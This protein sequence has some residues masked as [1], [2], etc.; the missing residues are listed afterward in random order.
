MYYGTISRFLTVGICAV[1]LGACGGGGGGLN[2]SVTGGASA[3]SVQVTVTQPAAADYMETSDQSVILEGTAEGRSGIIAV[4]WRNDRGGEGQASGG[5]SW[6]T[7]GITLKPG[8][9]SITIYASDSS[10]GW[11]SRTIVIHRESASTGSVTLS[12][13]APTKREDG[14][15]LTNLAGYYVRY[16]RLSGIYDFEIKIDNPGVTTYTVEELK[17]GVWYFVVSA[18]D[19]DGVESNYS[20]EIKRKVD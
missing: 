9:N 3:G 7:G 13:T 16:G 6:K 14:S 5:A 18:Y 10:G 12:W 4:S 2:Q 17:P 1:A 11:G 15:P 19:T 8:D 20:N